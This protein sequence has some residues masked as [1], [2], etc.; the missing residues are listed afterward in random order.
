MRLDLFSLKLFVDIVD[1]RSIG[2]GAAKNC[3]A[4]SAASKRMSDLEHT[5]GTQLLHRQSRGVVATEAGDIL[6]KGVTDTLSRL[7]QVAAAVSEHANGR[8]RPVRIYSNLT[9]LV[10]YLPES[11][12]AFTASHP[13]IAIELEEQPTAATLQAVSR[14]DADVGIVAPILPY[15]ANLVSFRYQVMRHVLVVPPDHALADQ[16]SVT[17]DK[18]A[19]YHFIG[20]ESDGGWDQLLRRVAEERG[21]EFR[22]RVRVNSFDGMCRMIASGLGVAIVPLPTAQLYGE[23][24]GLRLLTLDEPWAD[25]PLDICSRDVAT[26]T[27]G[28]RLLLDHLR[29]HR[30]DGS[31]LRLNASAPKAEYKVFKTPADH[32]AGSVDKGPIKH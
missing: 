24:A 17:F 27:T 23:S 16:G 1:L 22:V 19:V 26:L 9:S 4:V 14:G 18:A 31:P 32:A 20:M 12:K 11:L 15:P 2:K 28:A 29:H 30:L 21:C 13:T 8:K 6:H 5:L 25:M 3:I 10:H 7:Q